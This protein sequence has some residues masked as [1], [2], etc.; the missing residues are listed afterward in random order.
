MFLWGGGLECDSG[1]EGSFGDSEQIHTVFM[2]SS[3]V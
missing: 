3:N 2:S 1:G